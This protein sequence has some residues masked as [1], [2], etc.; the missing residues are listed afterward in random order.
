MKPALHRLAL[1]IL[2]GLIGS[3]ATAASKDQAPTPA[4]AAERKPSRAADPRPEF[5]LQWDRLEPATIERA[6]PGRVPKA[7]VFPAERR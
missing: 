7:P 3:T 6:T 2:A 1:G 4:P 5:P